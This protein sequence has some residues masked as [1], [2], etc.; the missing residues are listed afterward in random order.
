VTVVGAADRTSAGGTPDAATF[1]PVNGTTGTFAEILRRFRERTGLSQDELAARADVSSKAVGALERGE[2]RRPYPHTVR[3]L[4]D[5]LGL[6]SATAEAASVAM[7][8]P[9]DLEVVAVYLPAV[10][11]E[12]G[13][14]A[15]GRAWE[16]GRGVRPAH[17]P[18]LAERISVRPGRG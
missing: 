7:S 3:A 2:R 1:P 18:R 8:F 5:A 9:P 6:G 15:F 13:E 12:L 16:R 4:A 14:E 10:W 11:A 17:V